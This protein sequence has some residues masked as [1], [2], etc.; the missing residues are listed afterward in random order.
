MADKNFDSKFKL[1]YLHPRYIFT[2]TGILILAVLAYIPSCIRDAI[3]N[4]LA[5]CLHRLNI[6][7]KRKTMKTLTKAFPNTDQQEREQYYHR[8]VQIGI[9]VL[10]GYGESFFRSKKFVADRFIITGE[11]YYQEALATGKP[12]I[13]M[14]PHSWAIDRGGLFLSSQGLNMCTMMHTS[15]NE[16]YDWF[17]NSIRL[18]FG[19]KVYERSAG[20]K[21]IVRALKDGYHTFFLPDQDLG[22]KSAVFVDFFGSKKA[23]LV[24][25]PKLVKFSGAIVLPMFCCYNEQYHKYEVV[26]DQYFQDYPSDDEVADVR[27]MNAIT[28]RL[29]H[30]REGQYMWFLNFYRTPVPEELETTAKTAD[31]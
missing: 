23:S 5:R 7:F 26:F 20:I 14:A 8:F 30:D 4:L 15:G 6:K 25:L 2:W 18:K 1:R 13:F 29:V 12:I 31:K 28:E 11:N 16:V 19:G 9:K 27:H 10:F 22:A 3:A 24:V 17:M 21:S